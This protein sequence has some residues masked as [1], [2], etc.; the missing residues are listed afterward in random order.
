M[1]FSQL[2]RG[3]RA[4]QKVTLEMPEGDALSC[5][6]RPLNGIEEADVLA[7]ARAFAESRGVKEPK[8]GEPIYE[9]GKQVHTL[10]L[11]CLDA[12]SATPVP[13]F[14]SADE[15]LDGLDRDRRS[16]LYQLQQS[17]E[18]Q[19]APRPS[20]MSEQDFVQKCMD[21]CAAAEG[22]DG[23]FV[24][25]RPVSQWS[26]V[27]TLASLHVISLTLSSQSTSDAASDSL[28][29]SNASPSS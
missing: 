3:T 5:D 10:L 4:R 27:R 6:V 19:C 29:T 2:A 12:E 9:L 8:D 26:L 14:A 18:D 15:V 23:P 13:Y 20:R 24:M 25:L 28:T 11:A 16:Y 7:K 21:I 1:K 22:D 17:W